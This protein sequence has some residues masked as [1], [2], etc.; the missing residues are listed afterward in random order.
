[1]Y[2]K[3]FIQF[4]M[5]KGMNTTIPLL[6]TRANTSN[7]VIECLPGQT[8]DKATTTV[9]CTDA[10]EWIRPGDGNVGRTADI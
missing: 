5:K 7:E 6:S 9:G 10:V 4:K 3:G 2:N 1:M 8:E